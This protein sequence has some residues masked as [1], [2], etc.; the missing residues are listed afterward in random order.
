MID[1]KEKLEALK[2]SLE[3]IKKY[4]TNPEEKNLL[5]MLIENDENEE[6]SNELM[7]YLIHSNY[8]DY[9]KIKESKVKS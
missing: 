5:N 4:S 9:D 7:M 6:V 8:T 1:K 2:T 3:I